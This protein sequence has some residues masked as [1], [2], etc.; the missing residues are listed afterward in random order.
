VALPQVENGL[1]T[2]SFILCKREWATLQMAAELS[3]VAMSGP[4]QERSGHGQEE[5]TGGWVWGRV[6]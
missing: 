1:S 4:S 6:L 5:A 3:Q 2:L